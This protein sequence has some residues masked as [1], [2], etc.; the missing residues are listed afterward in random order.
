VG[1]LYGVA[2]ELEALPIADGGST[3]AESVSFE[4]IQPK[5]LPHKY[6][7]GE[8]C[9]GEAVAW[10]AALD[11]WMGLGMDRIAAYERKLTAYAT[12]RL[13][14]IPGVRVLG[15]GSER[16]AVLS[17]TV[18]G[19]PP[20]EVEQELDRRG[21][22]ARAGGLDAEPLLKALGVETA[23]R[24]SFMFYNT[25]EEADVLAEAV[26]EIARLH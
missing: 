6:E 15:D 4:K 12:G 11:Y 1:F 8:P 22:A 7:A 2:S 20:K 14:V 25:R 13:R 9:F 16:I 3:M 24:A 18:D 26:A 21:I 19:V 17:F 5:P 23:V 10:G